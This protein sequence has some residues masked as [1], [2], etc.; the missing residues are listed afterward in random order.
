MILLNLFIVQVGEHDGRCRFLLLLAFV[1]CL[2]EG[3]GSG[4]CRLFFGDHFWFEN[5]N[6]LFITDNLGFMLLLIL[7]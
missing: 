2:F 6:C 5:Y 4:V 7:V 3:I 1:A